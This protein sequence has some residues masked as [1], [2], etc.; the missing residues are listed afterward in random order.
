MR[1]DAIAK[2]EKIIKKQQDEINKASEDAKKFFAQQKQKTE[3]HQKRFGKNTKQA[4]NQV[5]DEETEELL[6]WFN[7]I[8][9]ENKKE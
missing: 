1:Q 4:L 5:Y 7:K 2:K 3:E 6:S 9:D 8:I